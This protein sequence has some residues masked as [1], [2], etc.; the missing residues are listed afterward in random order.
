MFTAILILPLIGCIIAGFFHRFIGE[1]LAMVIPT[2]ILFISCALSWYAFFTIH[3]NEHSITL[4]RWIGSGD[5]Q[6]D[7]SIRVDQ[8]TGVMLVVVT[9]VS[10][11]VH[12]Y[13]VGYMAE[14]D[15]KPR[16]FAYLS[17]FTFAMLALVTGDNLLQMF[18]GWEG[19]GV[20]SYLLIGFWF[21]KP[22][23][24]AAAIKAF[25]VNRI[26]D[27]GFLLGMFG[28]F[29]LTGSIQLDDVFKAGP[30]LAA[31]TTGFLG[32]E[33]SAIELICVLL[34]IGAMGKSAQLFLHTWLPDAMEGPT[35]VSAL[36][37]AATMVTAGVFLVCRMSPLFEYAPGAL[38]MVVVIGASTA[39]FAA[40]VALVQN[41]IKRVVAYSTCS[42]LGYMFVAAGVGAYEAAMFHL[43]T[44]AFFKA[45]LFLGSGSVIV[46]MHH[47]QDM[48]K[49]GGLRH[50]IPMTFYMMLAGTL[51]ITGVGIPLLTILDTPIGLAGFVSKDMIIE[52]SF[53][54]H[55]E[56][57]K[58][59]F[60]LLVAAAAMT[61][62]YSWRLIFMTFYGPT[63]A[64]PHTY[65]HAHESPNSMMIPLYVLA[66]GA[67]LAGMNWYPDFV[68][69]HEGAFWGKSI[70]NGEG[71]HVLHDA[72]GIPWLAK[73]APF[74]AM[75]LGFGL[76]YQ[77]YIR[78]PHLPAQMAAQ[79]PALYQFL[80]NKWYFDE[81]YEF[82]F[83]NPAKWVGRFLW[84]RGD[85]SV[86]DGFL[87]GV[88]MGLVPLLTRFAGRMQS[89]YLFHYAFVMLIG[90]SLLITWF[91]ITGGS[92]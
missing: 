84:K 88:A 21:K 15:G 14:D 22:T 80:L 51:A 50:K 87:N 68:G 52:S 38:T 23:A 63:R 17:F 13:S 91:A 56:A 60:V 92:H 9:S 53:A 39:F 67:A 30:E 62:F 49:M 36:I 73:L 74:I 41:D 69:H 57:G 20:A 35:P 4:M 61:S 7:W 24:N 16:F 3:G 55:S 31:T 18:F 11:L 12:L 65:D 48:R 89:G 77:M 32:Y 58:F 27:F 83:V 85:G 47:E 79:Q 46:A 54:A 76:A 82:L 8:L 40:T 70:F 26:G 45:L 66:V 71:N 10:S 2:T 5:L 1:K 75:V 34:F 37:H 19:V 72:H 42:Q 6:A 90:V 29:Y 64:D 81:I 43:F 25:I 28:L 59:A 33:V 86:I 44:H 78:K